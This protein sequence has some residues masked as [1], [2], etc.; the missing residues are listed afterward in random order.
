MFAEER[1]F[2]GRRSLSDSQM[3]ATEDSSLKQVYVSLSGV[4]DGRHVDL[5]AL[6]RLLLGC[7]L[8]LR[9]RIPLQHERAHGMLLELGANVDY[10][11]LLI[12]SRF[13]SPTTCPTTC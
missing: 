12:P 8:R 4:C 2:S 7:R 5:G 10:T 9:A 11:R 3:G 6:L 1:I 13:A